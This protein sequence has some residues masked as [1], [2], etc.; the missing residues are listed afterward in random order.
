M[1]RVSS[2]ISS[3]IVFVCALL[4]VC[5]GL[6]LFMPK[7]NRAD[8]AP[9]AVFTEETQ[10]DLNFSLKMT[11]TSR[12]NN[13]LAKNTQTVTNDL[14][15]E[16][17]YLCFNWREIKYLRFTVD[18]LY[19]GNEKTFLSAKLQVTHMQT[20][21]LTK[22]IGTNQPQDPALMEIQI[23]NNTFVG[24][25]LSYFIDSD[26]ALP[27]SQYS[28]N[29]HDFGLY[30]F[31]LVYNY[32]LDNQ[33]VNVSTGKLA[34]IY[35]AILPDTITKEMLNR[36]TKIMYSISSSNKL[37]NVFHLY[38]SDDTF[39]YVNP[40][41]IEWN[42]IGFDKDKM[43]YVLTKQTKENNPETYGSYEYIYEALQT[44]QGT[45]FIFD[46]NDIEGTWTA[47]CTISSDAGTKTMDLPELSTYKKEQ[48]SYVWLIITI[49]VAIV[50]V[51]T[52]VAILVVKF[53]KHDRVW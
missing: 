6:S 51:T 1:K 26:N 35:V 38:L 3:L 10:S 32:T 43:N 39:K 24:F 11:A 47:Y 16:I 49:A 29:G 33:N 41:S 15:E 7:T 52:I 17:T 46:S 20:D 27:E 2:K 34:G 44:T 45:N 50:V 12:S 19:S 30:K 18:S 9:Q 40:A 14:E 13:A 42:V 8:A 23:I 48:K 53:R 36:D 5:I 25:N 22:P 31:E 21:D 37:M 4:L 28:K